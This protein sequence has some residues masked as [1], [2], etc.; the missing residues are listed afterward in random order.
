MAAATQA[1]QQE[2]AQTRAQLEHQSA[3]AGEFQRLN[4]FLMQVNGAPAVGDLPRV[5]PKRQGLMTE[6]ESLHQLL[7]KWKE[8]G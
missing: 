5:D 3:T 6:C 2:L 7:V 8:M 1:M 4:A